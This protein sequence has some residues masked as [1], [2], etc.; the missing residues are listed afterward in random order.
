MWTLHIRS[1]CY[2]G[3][4]RTSTASRNI[5]SFIIF[6]ECGCD[7]YSDWTR[8]LRYSTRL[9][10]AGRRTDQIEESA[11]YHNAAAD[12]SHERRARSLARDLPEIAAIQPLRG[13]SLA[14]RAHSVP[15][16]LGFPD[17]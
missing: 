15:Q 17:R 4:G 16:F 7:G 1:N 14:K 6:G 5:H 2:N 9:Q 13:G 10:I 11:D 3:I 12:C 8:Y